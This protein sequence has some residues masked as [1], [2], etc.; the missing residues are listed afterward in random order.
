MAAP[1]L[2]PMCMLSSFE[3][4]GHGNEPSVT[5]AALGDDLPSEVPDIVH[6]APQH[7]HLHA[8]IVIEVDVHRRNRQIMVRVE[9]PVRRFGKSRS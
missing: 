6:R 1:R 9:D 4:D 3:F 7:R 5:D 8:A 2:S